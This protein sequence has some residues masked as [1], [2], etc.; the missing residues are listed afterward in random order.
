MKTRIR[1]KDFKTFSTDIYLP[2]IYFYVLTHKE[3]LIEVVM[4]E[5]LLHKYVVQQKVKLS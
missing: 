2:D 4:K 5:K 3:L 1:Q